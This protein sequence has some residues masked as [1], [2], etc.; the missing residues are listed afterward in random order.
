LVQYEDYFENN[1]QTNEGILSKN[2]LSTKIGIFVLTFTKPFMDANESKRLRFGETH[3]LGPKLEGGT[4]EIVDAEIFI[5]R[6]FEIDNGNG[7]EL[8]FK[9]YYQPLCSHAVRFVYSKEVAEDL[10]MEIFSQFWQKQLHQNITTSYRAYLFTTVR[11]AAYA[12]LRAEFSREKPVEFPKEADFLDTPINPQQLLQFNE[13]YIKIEEIIR[14]T[15]PQSQKVFV[16]SRFEG[17]KNATI[18]EELHLSIKTVEGHITKVLSL[19]RQS[20]RSNGLI[21]MIFMCIFFI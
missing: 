13:L 1:R 12:Y 10:V 16:M 4:S 5:K 17:K 21:S 2:T 18:A 3:H 7:Y 9:R 14:S 6:A 11:H 20:L 15:S 8:L 19:L